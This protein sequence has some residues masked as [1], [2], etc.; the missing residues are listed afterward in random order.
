LRIVVGQG[1]PGRKGEKKD[2]RKEGEWVKEQDDKRGLARRVEG[3]GREN[4]QEVRRR[5][6]DEGEERGSERKC[7]GKE[8]VVKRGRE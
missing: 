6:E 2:G 8:R 1:E 4:E 5:E 3:K 7:E